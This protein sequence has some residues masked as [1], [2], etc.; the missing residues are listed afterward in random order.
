MSHTIQLCVFSGDS[1]AIITRTM[2]RLACV[3]LQVMRS[4]D[5]QLARQAHTDCACPHHGTDQCSCQLVVLLVYDQDHKPITLI[6]HGYDDKTHLVLIDSPEQ[7][8]DPLVVSTIMRALS[9]AGSVEPKPGL[10]SNAG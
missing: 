9:A 1:Q 7:H 10:H 8:P 2:E 6:A 5:L 4:F 3:G